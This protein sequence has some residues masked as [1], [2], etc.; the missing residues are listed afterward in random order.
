MA[1]KLIVNEIEHTDGAGTAVTMA[2]ATIA[3]ATLTSATLPA[4]GITGVLPAGV[5][6]GSGLNTLS[7]S[8]LS[9][10]T[11]PDARFPAALPAIDGSALTGNVG[12]VIGV[13]HSQ[14]TGS[15]AG[16]NQ[17]AW[18]DSTVTITFTPISST[19][20]F[21]VWY[22][23]GVSISDNSGD[24]GVALRLKRVHNGVTLYPTGLNTDSGGVNKHSL[25][26]TNANPTSI[27][28]YQLATVQGYDADA[29]TTSS[30][31]YTLQFASYN[32]GNVIVGGV[33]SNRNQF[34]VLEVSS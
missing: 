33:Y 19:S 27:N 21:L 23:A 5:T 9:A 20:T 17:N 28:I 30:I 10:G 3:N 24:G 11:V 12:K 32:E 15:T 1:S 16:S 31:T 4:A 18:Y 7:A 22:N 13:Y 8:N 6:G 2:K 29:H 14:P 26:Y 25:W 34:T